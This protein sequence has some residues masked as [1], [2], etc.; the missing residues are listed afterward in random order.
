MCD[1]GITADNE[2]EEELEEERE[3][4]DELEEEVEEVEEEEEEGD[5]SYNVQYVED[6]EESDGEEGVVIEE[7]TES[8]S[9]LYNRVMTNRTQR[10]KRKAEDGGKNGKRNA[11]VEVEYELDEETTL[12]KATNHA[13]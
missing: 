12:K 3:D 8:I 1:F 2:G 13:W 10:L 4:E 9:D 6:F 7:A 5:M 11:R